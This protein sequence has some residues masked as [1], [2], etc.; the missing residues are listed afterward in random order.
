MK[1]RPNNGNS[2]SVVSARRFYAAQR[3]ETENVRLKSERPLDKENY[4]YFTTLFD[5]SKYKKEDIEKYQSLYIENL[6]KGVKNNK[7]KELELICRVLLTQ[8]EA[9]D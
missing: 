9:D 6:R 7:R 4:T 2:L 1:R 5:F 8:L 3:A